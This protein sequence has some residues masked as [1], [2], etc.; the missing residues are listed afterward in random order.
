MSIDP[1]FESPTHGRPGVFEAQL[2]GTRPA[3]AHE[4][5]TQALVIEDAVRGRCQCAGVCAPYQEAR[6]AERLWDGGSRQR[7]HRN[8]VI[9]RF[10]DRNSESLMH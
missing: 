1:A 4:A 3:C 10:Y 9:H 6:T 2:L 8:T 5:L 7:D